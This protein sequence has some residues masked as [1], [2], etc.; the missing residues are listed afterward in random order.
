MRLFPSSHF[1]SPFAVM[2]QVSI[3]SDAFFYSMLVRAML[4]LIWFRYCTPPP[5]QSGQPDD[6]RYRKQ[7]NDT[8][9]TWSRNKCVTTEVDFAS[10]LAD[11]HKRD[12]GETYV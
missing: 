5:C 10:L 1:F 9:S 6:N 12:T 11:K 4:Q 7:T 2:L 3:C 8:I